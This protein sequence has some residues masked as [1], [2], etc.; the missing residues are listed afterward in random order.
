MRDLKTAR[1]VSRKSARTPHPTTLIIALADGTVEVAA[2]VRVED[3][4]RDV[5]AIRRLRRLHGA[6]A[7]TR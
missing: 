6:I 7:P 1:K 5:G 2:F 4:L 3:E